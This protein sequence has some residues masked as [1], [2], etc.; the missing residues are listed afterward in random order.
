M[1]NDSL[2]IYEDKEGNAVVKVSQELLPDE[3]LYIFGYGS[4]I[5]RPGDLLE[6]LPSYDVDCIS[7]SRLF[8]QF[9]KDHRGSV[10]FPGLVCT[11]VPKQD[12]DEDEDDDFAIVSTCSGKIWLVPKEQKANVLEQL[13]FR[14]KGGYSR[15]IIDVVLRKSSSAGAS[16]TLN[17]TPY[18]DEGEQCRAV[19]YL[20]NDENPNFFKGS[21]KVEADVFS[22]TKMHSGDI[23]FH[24]KA[25]IIATAVGPSGRNIDYLINLSYFLHT[26]KDQRVNELVLLNLANET[27]KE[28]ESDMKDNYLHSLCQY[29]WAHHHSSQGSF[30][31]HN[32]R[33]YI[34]IEKTDHFLDQQSAL[35]SQK[36][37]LNVLVG[38]GSTDYAL[39]GQQVNPSI[40]SKS[41]VK[42][43]ESEGFISAAIP[44]NY[45]EFVELFSTER[46]RTSG[47]FQAIHLLANGGSSGILLTDGTNY[48]T[49]HNRLVLWGQVLHDPESP[50]HLNGNKTLTLHGIL[51][52]CMGHEHI[53]S[54]HESGWLLQIQRKQKE[55]SD[56]E[57]PNFCRLFELGTEQLELE[58]LYIPMG[59]RNDDDDRQVIHAS[60]GLRHNLAITANGRGYAWGDDRWKQVQSKTAEFTHPLLI[61]LVY[62]ACGSRH[63]VFINNVGNILSFGSNKHCSLGRPANDS[64]KGERGED[65][66]PGYVLLSGKEFEGVKWIRVSCG[67][68]HNVAKGIRTDGS[69]VFAG[70]GRSDL[71]QLLYAKN[72]ECNAIENDGIIKEKGAEEEK[73]REYQPHLLA[74]LPNG[75]QIIEVWCGAEHTI[76]ADY[77][78][79]LWSSGWDEHGVL[80]KGNHKHKHDADALNLTKSSKTME[81]QWVPVLHNDGQQVRVDVS[82]GTAR[83]GHVAAG[84]GHNLVVSV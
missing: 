26:Y 44:V 4:L 76:A 66:T 27:L 32:T 14:E 22:L 46:N 23:H 50:A 10:T 70:W 41:E 67:W 13:D 21:R 65:S 35:Y 47:D 56:R 8:G 9:S 31:K 40:N 39:L 73:E 71:G 61:N 42:R 48:V 69:I 34:S 54:L 43:E 12:V 37:Q 7:H 74:P 59:E 18:H 28:N 53:L 55:N 57:V 20:A 68:S 1:W 16:D 60:A 80:G 19:V 38:W 58:E 78:G 79:C 15:D 51:A 83:E 45:P 6:K 25:R 75:S 77:Q 30:F 64:K 62:S 81:N 63:S 84:G 82:F 33:K 24:R 52:A 2:G 72:I 11:L 5:W 49:D 36:G 3:P 29:V 17:N